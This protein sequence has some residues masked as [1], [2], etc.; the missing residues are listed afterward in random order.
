[1]Q[2]QFSYG[3]LSYEEVRRFLIETDSEFLIPL[4]TSV[5]INEYARKLSSFSDFSICR[6]SGSI[7]GMIS[8]YTNQ[9]P[10]GYISNVCVKKQYQG[11]K[12][13]SRMYRLLI[14]NLKRLGILY[15][16]LEVN[17]ENS[18]AQSVYRH[19]GFRVVEARP[20]YNKLLMELEIG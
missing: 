8:C 9:P 20:E 18:N 2:L 10:M 16:R 7:I 4:S 19:Y 15:L 6:D 13:F 11:Q 3:K 1:M 5:D 12:V 17:S 14:L